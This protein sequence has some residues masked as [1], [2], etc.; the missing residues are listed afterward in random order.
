[1]RF[2]FRFDVSGTAKAIIEADTMEEAEELAGDLDYEELEE[3]DFSWNVD[4]ITQL[5]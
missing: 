4:T 1:M 3:T 5:D 2:E